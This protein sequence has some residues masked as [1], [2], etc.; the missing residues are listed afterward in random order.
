MEGDPLADF[1]TARWGMHTVIGGR[2]RF[3]PNDHESWPLRRATLLELNDELVA[4]AGV[5]VTGPPS[6]VLYSPGVH[7]R[8]AMPL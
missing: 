5:A 8:F 1:L 6:S 2:T 4:A 7:A 3:V